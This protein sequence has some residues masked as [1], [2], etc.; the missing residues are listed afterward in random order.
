MYQLD[1]DKIKVEKLMQQ[2]AMQEAYNYAEAA[3]TAKSEFLSRMSHD[4]RTP[5]NAI[6]GFTAIAEA[7]IEAVSYTHLDVYKRQR[8]SS[9]SLPSSFTGRR[10]SRT[11]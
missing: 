1:I 5:M 9:S 2:Q 4:I 11:K 7:N 3:N 6:V 10:E 8:R